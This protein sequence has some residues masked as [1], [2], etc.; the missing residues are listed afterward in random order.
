MSGLMQ[1]EEAYAVEF[2]K[3][4]E[5]VER[6]KIRYCRLAE[7]INTTS[8]ERCCKQLGASIEKY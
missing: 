8:T 5:F 3:V 1:S 6:K 2:T 7:Y 4:V